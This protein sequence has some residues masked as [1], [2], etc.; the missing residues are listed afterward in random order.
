MI[1]AGAFE[2][3]PPGPVTHL[4]YIQ[5]RGG[6]TP[7]KISDVTKNPD[8]TKDLVAQTAA[9]LNQL[10]GQYMDARTPYRSRTIIQYEK[11]GGDYDHLAR[12]KEWSVEEPENP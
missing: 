7:D 10:I 3:V 5:V 2:D 12:V 1:E 8:A 6:T 9:G 4:R 11:Y